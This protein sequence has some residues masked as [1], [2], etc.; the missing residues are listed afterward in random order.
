MPQ[1][2]GMSE[3]ENRSGWVGVHPHRGRGKGDGIG[4]GRSEKGKIFEI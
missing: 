3:Q 1:D 4:K 2:R